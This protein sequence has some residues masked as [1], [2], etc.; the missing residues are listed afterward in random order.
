MYLY[1]QPQPPASDCR[2]RYPEASAV[3][4]HGCPRDI[5][6][7]SKIK[8]PVL[9]PASDLLFPQLSLS[10]SLE[11]VCL[12]QT[13]SPLNPLFHSVQISGKSFLF[14][15]FQ[16]MSRIQL[17]LQLLHCSSSSLSELLQLSFL[18]GLPS[19]ALAL[20]VCSQQSCRSFFFCPPS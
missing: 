17:F 18:S 10:Q 5:S 14:S 20:V 7:V 6:Q 16:N 1:Y 4:P 3:S 13:P 15:Y 11:T 9:N 19:S 12:G 8:I 2:P